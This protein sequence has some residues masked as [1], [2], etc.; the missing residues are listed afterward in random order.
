MEDCNVDHDDDDISNGCK[1]HSRRPNKRCFENLV[2]AP[3]IVD[4]EDV[5]NRRKQVL[6]DERIFLFIATNVSKNKN[7][8]RNWQ[9]TDP[10]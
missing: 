4:R 2:L 7:T 9:R 1:Y 5:V 10:K 6:K 8:T 3:N